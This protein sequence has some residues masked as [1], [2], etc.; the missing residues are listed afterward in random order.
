MKLPLNLEGQ[1]SPHINA[2]SPNNHAIGTIVIDDIIASAKVQPLKNVDIYGNEYTT[3]HH[4]QETGESFYDNT[5]DAER[6]AHLI[7]PA[8]ASNN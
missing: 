4:K 6:S 7:K 1:V 2:L 8:M 5:M 3:S